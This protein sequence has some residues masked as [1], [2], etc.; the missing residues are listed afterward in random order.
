MLPPLNGESVYAPESEP[1][2]GGPERAIS[3]DEFEASFG[4]EIRQLLNLDTWRVGTDLSR[5]Y[6]RIEREV[7]EA[8]LKE[9]GFQQRIRKEVF[10]LL[11]ARK[12]AAKECR[13][14]QCRPKTD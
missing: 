9:T 1:G 2:R 12:H 14:A 7:R 8:V 6:S 13:K 5:E 10:P 3:A 11:K 4:E